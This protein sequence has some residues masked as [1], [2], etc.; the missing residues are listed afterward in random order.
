[1]QRLLATFGFVVGISV[2]LVAITWGIFKLQGPGPV[3]QP[4]HPT[5][6][7]TS[8]ATEAVMP[9]PAQP[10]PQEVQVVFQ[11]DG[12]TYYSGK[13]PL[14]TVSGQAGAP[15][16]IDDQQVVELVKQIPELPVPQGMV[17]ARIET[18]KNG[19]PR[20]FLRGPVA[21]AI[22]RGETQRQI[23]EALSK[24]PSKTAIAVPI[25]LT[26]AEAAG[27]FEA[28]REKQ[29]FKT[30]L[31]S[32]VTVHVDHM[33][34]TGRNENLRLA[35]ER[36]DG[37]VVAPGEEFNFD[38]VVKERSR[39]N[40][41][42]LAGVISN[43]KVIPG[44]GGGIC[45][46]STTLYRVALQSNL[47]ITERHNHSIYDGIE[48]ADRGLDAAVAWGSK[49][50]RFRNTLSVPILLSVMSGPGR[51]QAAIYA[52]EKPFD[53]VDVVTRNERK[54]PLE[55]KTV[56]N[57]KL[58]AGQVKVVQP[59]VIGYTIESYRIVT[60][61]GISREER[62]SKDKYLTFPRIEEVNN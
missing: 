29:G 23:R 31:A 10:A 3:P 49:N 53:K 1:M 34:D 54:L 60:V 15:T 12:K 50:F 40:G 55:K 59:G 30:C 16:A 58:K 22:D 19:Q 35:A 32:F 46:V 51:V 24:D 47:T 44:L 62:L 61:N 36:I 28:L 27:G 17:S 4:S 43:G 39:K 57:A 14:L 5:T 18:D 56:I 52:P 37:V 25:A 45:Q 21:P 2:I 26:Q 6:V 8:P 42:Q 7:V 33:D 20:R 13:A 41:F 9:T 38:K 48:Y 11:K